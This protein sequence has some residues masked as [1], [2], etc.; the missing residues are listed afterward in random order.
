MRAAIVVMVLA[1]LGAGLPAQLFAAERKQR[2]SQ[3]EQELRWKY[4][5]ATPRQIRNAAAFE[6]GGYYEQL[7][8]EH[9]VGSRSWW[10]LRDRELGG[11]R[12]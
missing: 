4:P 6:R 11:D 8:S 9:P 2:T 3:L 10:I 12:N 5:S 7:A 1:A